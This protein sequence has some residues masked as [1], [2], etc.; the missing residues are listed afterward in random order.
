MA[1]P[2]P[3]YVTPKPCVSGLRVVVSAS[4]RRLLFDG[5]YFMAS[6]GLMKVL[7]TKVV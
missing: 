3:I 5:R 7:S 6:A 2:L 1:Q 4:A